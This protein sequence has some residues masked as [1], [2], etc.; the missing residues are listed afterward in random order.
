MPW[1][2]AGKL[3]TLENRTI[4]YPGHAAQWQAFR[5][6][7]L[8]EQEPIDIQGARV[9]PRDVLHAVLG[10]RLEV[11]G[12]FEDAV[13][14]RVIARGRHQGRS[15]EAQL[16]LIDF[17]DPETGLTSMQRTTGWDGAIVAEMMAREET[18][19]G[20]VPR[21]LSVDPRRYVEELRARGFSIDEERR[22]TGESAPESKGT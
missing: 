7:G 19:R 14:I 20:A 9:R 5:D 6:A 11:R 1:S 16:D 21:E 18:T 13:V 3:D 22:F 15:A 10:P 2:F 8:F 4:R 17:F 12:E